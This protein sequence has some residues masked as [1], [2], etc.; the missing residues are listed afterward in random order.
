MVRRNLVGDEA[1]LMFFEGCFLNG[2][3]SHRDWLGWHEDDDQ[4][5]DHSKPIAI[6]TLYGGP[7]VDHP[8]AIQFREK[9]GEVDGKMTYGEP[10]TLPLEQGSLCLMPAGFQSTHQHRIPK[11]G[12]ECRSRISLTFRGL[13]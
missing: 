13:V 1:N 6:V 9:L 2:Y 12:F 4:G 3:E 10:E 7:G 5:I 11:A 8:R